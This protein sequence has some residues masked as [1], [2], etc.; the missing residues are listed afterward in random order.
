MS[1]IAAVDAGSNAIRL[2]IVRVEASGTATVVDQHRYALR[3]GASTYGRGTIEARTISRLLVIFSDIAARMRRAG[4]ERYRAVATAGLR[5]AANGAAVVRAIRRTTGVRLEIIDGAQ[6]S[7]LV[8]Q[9]L[10]AAL[11]SIPRGALFM[12][13]GGG[14]LELDRLRIRSRVVIAPGDRAPA[15][16]ASGSGRGGRCKRAS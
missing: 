13:M 12:D 10:A 2:S 11:G 8:H 15:T 7:K 9:A 16:N 14:S 3:L 5:D 4:V 6:E 1:V